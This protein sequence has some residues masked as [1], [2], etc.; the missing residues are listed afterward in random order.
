MIIRATRRIKTVHLLLMTLLCMCY[1][2]I[3]RQYSTPAAEVELASMEAHSNVAVNIRDTVEDRHIFD[4]EHEFKQYSHKGLSTLHNLCIEN[5]PSG[6]KIEIVLNQTVQRKILVVYSSNKDSNESLKVAHT[7]NRPHAGKYEI[8]YKMQHR[9]DAFKYIEE[10]PAYFVV[11]S[12]TANL[13]H[14]WAD[15]T[16]GLYLTLKRTNRLGSKIANQV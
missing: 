6:E 7:I 1:W 11:S 13:H 14:F 8:Q 15:S 10:Y 9:P 12:C 3:P 5:D 4:S 16:E 2:V